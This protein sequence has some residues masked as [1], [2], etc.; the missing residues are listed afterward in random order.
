VTLA[1][2][3]LGW[4]SKRVGEQRRAVELVE[5]L[6]GYVQYDYDRIAAAE[7][8]N[9]PPPRPVWRPGMDHAVEITSAPS[10][11]AWLVSLTG[12]HWWATVERITLSQEQ[13]LSTADVEILSRLPS[14]RSL[15]LVN[16]RLRGASLKAWEN[17]ESLRGLFLWG[18][19][20]DNP[21]L[22]FVSHCPKLQFVEITKCS[23]GDAGL[24]F[25]R[26]SPLTRLDVSDTQVSD[27][28]LAYL[29]EI[30]TLER[31]YATST[32]VQG[33]GLRHLSGLRALRV[34][35]LGRT[36][37]TDEGLAQLGR[38]PALSTVIVYDCPQVTPS[39]VNALKRAFPQLSIHSNAVLASANP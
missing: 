9:N 39:G 15:N 1:A 11:P 36:A 33:P 30:E 37:I 26:G 2:C 6:G 38:L 3:W 27:I 13:T 34:L 14:L 21:Q 24:A 35:E 32:Q 28:G 31:L 17:L 23:F 5:R 19:D 7:Y 12:R 29:S 8:R 20:L 10:A 4:Q 25:L 16:C 18:C 22:A